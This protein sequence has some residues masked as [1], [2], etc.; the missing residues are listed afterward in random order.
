L[1]WLAGVVVALL[2]QVME[3]VVVVRVEFYLLLDTL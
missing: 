1:S 2:I 3:A